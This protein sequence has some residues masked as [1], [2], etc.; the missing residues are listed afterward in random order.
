LALQSP[1]A[2]DLLK[3]LTDP[4]LAPEGKH[5]LS[6]TV[7]Y[8]SYELKNGN[9]D[10]QAEGI[11]KIGIDIIKDYSSDFESSIEGK[12]VITPFDMEEVY[13]LQE[14]NPDHGE[15]TLN[16]SMWMRPIPG[17]AQYRTP[18]AGL[19]LCSASTHPGGGVTGLNSRS[20]SRQILRDL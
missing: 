17:F 6:V 14:G 2:R 1:Y 15:M 13:N 20:A 3:T 5:I 4:S 9:W 19:Y 11:N 12:K 18:I 10:E 8:R 16:Q 7:K